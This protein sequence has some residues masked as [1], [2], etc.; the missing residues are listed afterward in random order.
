MKSLVNGRFVIAVL[1]VACLMTVLLTV[2][3]IRSGS[4]S[5]GEYDPWLDIND[6][7][8]IDM[9]DIGSVA[10]AFG[11]SGTSINK[12]AMLL[13]IQNRVATLENQ[14][15]AVKTIRFYE[16]NETMN[17]NTI[18][19][20]AATFVWTPHNT[21]DNAILSIRCYFQ[22]RCES[23]GFQF[24]VQIN[25]RQGGTMG[26]LVSSEYVWSYVWTENQLMSG[27]QVNYPNQDNYTL[28]F[29]FAVGNPA[30]PAYVKDINIVLQVIDGLSPN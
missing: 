11:A 23:Q 29:S 28:K 8:E 22:Y 13:D 26:L 25:N 10:R 27:H 5:A 9:K 20:D 15:D 1:T 16:Q 21:T 30:F 3:P 12:T 18:F 19:K 2:A 4:P 24:R 17:D 14:S 6:D 7:G